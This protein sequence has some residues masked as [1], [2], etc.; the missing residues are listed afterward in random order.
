MKPGKIHKRKIDPVK[1][2]CKKTIYN[3]LADAEE[4][5]AY[6]QENKFV[7][8]LSAYRCLVCGKWH[9]TSK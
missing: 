7:K 9:L 3:S 1:L 8:G 4:A 5:I 2:P 6:I